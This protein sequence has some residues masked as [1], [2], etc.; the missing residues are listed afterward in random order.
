[1]ASKKNRAKRCSHCGGAMTIR[2]LGPELSCISCGRTE[3]HY[4]TGTRSCQNCKSKPINY[5]L[6]II[7]E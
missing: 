1:M 3:D 6:A 4:Q 5:V 2:Y 7:E